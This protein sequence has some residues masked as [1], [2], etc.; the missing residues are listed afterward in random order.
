MKVLQSPCFYP[1]FYP[2][3]SIYGLDL[4][5]IKFHKKKL[6]LIIATKLRLK[7]TFKEKNEMLLQCSYSCKFP[8]SSIFSSAGWRWRHPAGARSRFR[9][10]LH[11]SSQAWPLL[12]TSNRGEIAIAKCGNYADPVYGV[13]TICHQVRCLRWGH[14]RLFHTAMSLLICYKM[15]CMRDISYRL[16][17]MKYINMLSVYAQSGT[18]R[19]FDWWI[20]A[21]FT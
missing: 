8:V 17:W 11:P 12:P 13:A 2:N 14:P 1:N 21:V 16:I 3:V 9:W 4:Q 18:H 15:F 10:K 20:I 7:N 5:T 6:L 19:P